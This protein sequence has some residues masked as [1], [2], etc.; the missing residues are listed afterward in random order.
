MSVSRPSRDATTLVGRERELNILRDRL[1]TAL[2]GQVGLVLIGGE[3]G[4]G[5][6]ALA[7]RGCRAAGARGALV[8]I[9]RCFDLTET[10][11]YGPWVELFRH[12]QPT[13]DMPPLPDAF[14]VRG[15]VGTV[16]SQDALFRQVLDFLTALTAARPI[17][18]LL[19]DLHWADPA[20]LELLRFLARSL[21]ALPLL[22]IATYRSDELTRGHP[23][24]PLL[25]LLVRE[26][27]AERIDLHPL[28]DGAVRA[29]VEMRYRIAGGEADRLVAYLQRRAE[30]NALFVGEVLRA[31]EEGGALARDGD[32]WRL[33][34]LI[35]QA[36]PPLLRQVIEG[37]AARLDGESQRLLA[38][39]AVIGQE[40]LLD[41]WAAVAGVDE[42]ALL[43]AIEAASAARLIEAAADGTAIR[44][45][46]A[47]IREALYEGVLPPRRR[48]LH[49][50][51]GEALAAR[52]LPDVDA[53]ASHFRRAGDDR[54]VAWLMVA[55]ERAQ[56]AYAWVTAA[57][58]YEAALNLMEPRGDDAVERGWL[59]RA[60]ARLRIHT[61]PARSV[62]LLEDALALGRRAGDQALIAVVLDRLGV[63]LSY[64][65]QMRAGVRQ[66]AA[67]VDASAGLTPEA[68]ARIAARTDAAGPWEPRVRGTWMLHAATAG[69]LDAVLPF[70]ERWEAMAEPCTISLQGSSY[71]GGWRALAIAYA[72]KGEVAAAQ[73][74]FMRTIAIYR[75]VGHHL[76]VGSAAAILLDY[77]MLPYRADQPDECERWA[78]TAAEAIEHAAGVWP[79]LRTT[80]RASYDFA[81]GRWD[82]PSLAQLPVVAAAVPIVPEWALLAR[83]A[84][85]RGEV[86]RA[87]E[88][89]RGRLPEGAATQPGDHD[90][91]DSLALLRVAAELS[92][93]AGDPGVATAWLEAHDRWLAWSG[94]V[95]GQSEGQA[96]WACHY[97]QSGDMERAHRHA[98]CAL[99]CASDPRQPL[100]IL[101]AQRLLGELD[102][103][104]GRYDDAA[105]HLDA[106][107]RLADA[108]RAPYERALTLLALAELRSA[109]DER[110]VASNLLAEV[111]GLCLPLRAIPALARVDILIERLA[112]APSPA[113]SYPAGL[114]KREVEVLRLIAAGESNRV[115]AATLFISE[116]TVNRHLTNL[117]TKIDAHS[118]AEATAYALRHHLA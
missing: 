6:T 97:R 50:A 58:H 49:R 36:V 25:P 38:V 104:E 4:A 8:L 52:E 41:V 20:S 67:A 56:H 66:L 19:D 51:A 95:L 89:V 45:V 9:G 5:K 2:T 24:S 103:A 64:T 105:R 47:L 113:T 82:A 28:D 32:G 100:A 23:L 92:L 17:V 69:H 30:G 108:C 98:E 44:F 26:A 78:V 57:D 62:L 60:I 37:R 27:G 42:E 116:R 72:M 63:A 34:D 33:G 65:G 31:L 39:A 76:E 111:R 12:Y 77:V 75:A 114:T 101:G 74:A 115:I 79:E 40:V 21:A 10:P 90:L 86:E 102:T 83:L 81:A 88:W 91:R 80:V 61:D 11:P 85:E 35:G 93:D 3:A 53:V 1:A 15:T 54:A 14:A 73:A 109:T 117:Y 94:A 13:A 112:R 59:L 96:L 43:P 70:A 71:A 48:A 18:L 68:L 22:L 87:W 16:P 118:K 99:A 110:D 46:H 55:G 7:E 106:S 107:L 84:R 29:L